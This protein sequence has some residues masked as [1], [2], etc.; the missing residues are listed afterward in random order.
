MPTDV[1]I[2]LPTD[3]RIIS[4]SRLTEGME[5]CP[6]WYRARVKP[7]KKDQKLSRLVQTT[8]HLYFLRD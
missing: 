7:N 6:R 3:M 4:L 8:V 5:I 1:R 2:F